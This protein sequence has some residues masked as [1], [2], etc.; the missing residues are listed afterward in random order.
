MQ[1]NPINPVTSSSLI[2][3]NNGITIVDIPNDG[4]PAVFDWPAVHELISAI[5]CPD[6]NQTSAL[7]VALVAAYED[8][9][10][11]IGTASADAVALTPA[12]REA[13][14]MLEVLRGLAK[15]QGAALT[16]IPDILDRIDGGKSNG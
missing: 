9:A 5:D 15:L 16:S 6:D 8:G 12:Q 11:N 7:C 10:F 2:I 14:A 13:E 4:R 3:Q 1:T